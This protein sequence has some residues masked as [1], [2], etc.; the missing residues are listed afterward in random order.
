[1]QT[2]IDT[3]SMIGPASS[4]RLMGSPVGVATAAKTSTTMMIQRHQL[5]RRRPGSTPAKFSST[6]SSG[7]RKPIPN[8]RIVRMKKDR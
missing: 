6:R 3:S 1:M 8:T 4:I 7:T 5:S 2:A